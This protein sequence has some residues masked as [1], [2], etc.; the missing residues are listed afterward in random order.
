M[1]DGWV[2]LSYPLS[3]STPTSATHVLPPEIEPIELISRG[4]VANLYRIRIFNHC[5]SHID[6]PNHFSDSGR[7]LFQYDPAEFIFDSPRVIDVDVPERS[8]ITPADLEGAVGEGSSADLLLLR[9]GFS[10][11]RSADSERYRWQAPGLAAEAVPWMVARHPSLRAIA[12]DFISMEWTADLS[13]GFHTHKAAAEAG[14]LVME[15]L[16]LETLE[17]REPKRVIALPLIFEEV[18]S[19]P[20]TVIAQVS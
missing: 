14:L 11:Y 2:F 10:R 4:D 3:R 20:A 6:S 17:R 15:D 18:D 16:N 9:T 5:G 12:M 13:H 1:G 7:R 8:L 19:G